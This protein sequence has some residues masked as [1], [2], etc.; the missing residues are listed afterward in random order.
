MEQGKTKRL[1]REDW[2]KAALSLCA[3]GIDSVKV[4]PLAERLGVTTGSFYWHFKNRRELLEALLD[5]WE[6]ETTDM[7]IAAAR[8]FAGSPTNRILFVMETVMKDNLARYDLPIWQWAQSDTRA[9]IVF[10]RVLKK[11]FSTA[12]WMFSEAGFS[13]E[14]AEIRGRM[15][16]IYMMG[17]T[18]LIPDSMARRKEFIKLKHAILTAQEQ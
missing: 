12:A 10:K 18:T 3:A 16:V 17:E 9:S 5:Y 2:L 4:A 8:E 14:Q 13:R 15:M 1:A 6:H 11:R 7:A